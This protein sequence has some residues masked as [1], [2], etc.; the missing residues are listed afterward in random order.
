MGGN[1]CATNIESHS[2]EKRDKLKKLGNLMYSDS[3]GIQVFEKMAYLNLKNGKIGVI[4]S[5]T[6]GFEPGP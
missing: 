2:E 5:E 1:A 4:L 6:A 3:A